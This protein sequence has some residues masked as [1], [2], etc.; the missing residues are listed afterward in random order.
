MRDAVAEHLQEE[1][2]EINLTPM[3]DVVFIMLIFF[4]VTA[5]FVKE[6]GIQVDRPEAVT[7][8]VPDRGSIFIAVSAQN[9]FWIDQ[10]SVDLAGL[11]PIIERLHSE[12]PEGG[13]VIQADNEAQN[14]YV[15]AAMDASKEAGVT[16]VT[17][18]A[19]VP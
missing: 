14:E 4:I 2:A 18:A 3:L 10:R 1:E 8:M 19:V 13:V 6:P 15:L 16:D 12:N 17:L 5:V 11:G 9:E 7:A